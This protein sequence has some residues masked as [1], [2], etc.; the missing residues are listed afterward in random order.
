MMSEC[1]GGW[2]A[3]TGVIWGGIVSVERV[4]EDTSG[5]TS[6]S[7]SYLVSGGSR[8]QTERITI[9]ASRRSGC[10]GG[11]TAVQLDVA[12]QLRRCFCHCVHFCLG[13]SLF[14]LP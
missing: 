1:E 11:L 4:D 9:G 6:F 2:G 7:N 5:H 10:E 14:E 12:G 8:P 3:Y 13:V